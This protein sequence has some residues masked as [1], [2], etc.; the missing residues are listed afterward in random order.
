M[1]ILG[2]QTKGGTWDSA[3]FNKFPA[4]ANGL[5]N[6]VYSALPSSTPSLRPVLCTQDPGCPASPVTSELFPAR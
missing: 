4:G 5:S 3:F 6:G 2:P 1:Q